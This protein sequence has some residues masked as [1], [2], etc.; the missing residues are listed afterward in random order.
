MKKDLQG[1]AASE[2]VNMVPPCVPCLQGTGPQGELWACTH[3]GQLTS[4]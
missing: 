1:L 4:G 3:A 2:E